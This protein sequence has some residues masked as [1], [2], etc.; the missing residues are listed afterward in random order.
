MQKFDENK[1]PTQ[2]NFKNIKGVDVMMFPKCQLNFYLP[3]F[4]KAL[5]VEFKLKLNQTESGQ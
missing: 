4:S 1:L 3:N 5:P 2:A